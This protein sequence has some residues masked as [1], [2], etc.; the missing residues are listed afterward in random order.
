LE[1]EKG[2][3]ES[4]V[5]RLTEKSAPG[6]GKKQEKEKQGKS[7]NYGSGDVR[8]IRSDGEEGRGSAL[9]PKLR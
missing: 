2:L 1:V 3:K 4:R 5:V 9:E 8:V 6:G 7:S